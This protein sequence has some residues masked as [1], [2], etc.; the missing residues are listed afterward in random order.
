VRIASGG[1][2]FSGISNQ[3]DFTGGFRADSADGTI[4]ANA[5]TA[6][7]QQAGGANSTAGSAGVAAPSLAGR[8][9]RVVAAGGVDIRQPGLRA[10]GERLLYTAS[11]QVFLLTGDTKTPPKATDANGVTTGAALRFHSSCD[12]SG[13][14]SVEALSAEPGEQ[15][16]RVQTDTR[17]SN[18]EKREKGKR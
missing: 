11:D 7:L 5:G 16:Q 10:T 14:V 13:G 12:A 18:D 3:A 9:E 15:P 2:V 6:Y 1:L 8:V 17:V 4:R